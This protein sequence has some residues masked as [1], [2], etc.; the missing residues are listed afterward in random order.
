VRYFLE[1]KGL[2]E[3]FLTLYEDRESWGSLSYGRNGEG[4]H[5]AGPA[6]ID[7]TTADSR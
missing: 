4:S 3:K 5:D 7:M 2:S 6:R 1:R